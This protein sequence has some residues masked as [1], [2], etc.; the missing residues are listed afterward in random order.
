MLHLTRFDRSFSF[1]CFRF[2]GIPTCHHTVVYRWEL[3]RQ[4]DS[5]V[6]LVV[7]VKLTLCD[8]HSSHCNTGTQERLA[9]QIRA[10][11]EL[12]N[13]LKNKL[14]Q[15]EEV[16]TLSGVSPAQHSVVL[17]TDPVYLLH[18]IVHTTAQKSVRYRLNGG[19]ELPG[20]PSLGPPELSLSPVQPHLRQ[21]RQPGVLHTVR[22]L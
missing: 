16:V 15:P 21:P 19:E 5:K 17:H 10:G 20:F 12:M 2:P 3:E 1:E 22:I 18:S 11:V 6:A 13:L 8:A 9:I 4:L 14:E 7:A